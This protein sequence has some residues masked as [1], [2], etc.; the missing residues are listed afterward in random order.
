MPEK[1]MFCWKCSLQHPESLV[2]C[3][4]CGAANAPGQSNATPPTVGSPRAHLLEEE[5]TAGN[6]Q[7]RHIPG[8]Y[9]LILLLVL[10]VVAGALFN[11][12]TG[13]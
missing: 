6:Q 10:V 1:L 5:Y 13:H 12:L 3:P 2:T 11:L 7:G 8:G 9:S 4:R